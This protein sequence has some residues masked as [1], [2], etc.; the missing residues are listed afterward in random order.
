MYIACKSTAFFELTNFSANNMN[1]G[2]KI[3]LILL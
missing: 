2:A 3:C 1:L